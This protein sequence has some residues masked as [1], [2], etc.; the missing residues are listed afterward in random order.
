MHLANDAKYLALD[1]EDVLFHGASA[2][3]QETRVQFLGL[4]I[5]VEHGIDLRLFSLRFAFPCELSS[6]TCLDTL[7]KAHSHEVTDGVRFD[8]FSNA[9][10]SRITST[11]KVNNTRTHLEVVN[12]PSALTTSDMRATFP[13]FVE[14][15]LAVSRAMLHEEASITDPAATRRRVWATNLQVAQ[16][17]IDGLRR[18]CR[19]REGLPV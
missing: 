15:M 2:I 4:L 19:R 7:C 3:H 8:Y 1:G 9:E 13:A 18:G 16:S 10:A 17:S 11:R 12:M 6:A 5:D 14:G